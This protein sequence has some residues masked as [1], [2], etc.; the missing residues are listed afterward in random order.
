MIKR[1]ILSLILLITLS[2]L[3]AQTFI[4]GT[5]D[6]TDSPN[7][8][9]DEFNMTVS[10]VGNLFA[11]GNPE[12][13]SKLLNLKLK[14]THPKTPDLTITL[15]SPEGT[16][17]I[18]ADQI[19]DNAPIEAV[20]DFDGTVL[21]QIQTD[22]DIS[23]GEN[24]FTGNFLPQGLGANDLFGSPERFEAFDN[25]N[26]DGVWTLTITDGTST[27]EGTL[28]DWSM[29]F[30][31]NFK[32]TLTDDAISIFENDSTELNVIANDS[33]PENGLDTNTF[34]LI[35]TTDSGS[36]SI[37]E[38]GIVKY[39]PITGF[40]GSDTFTYS[41]CDTNQTSLCDT[42]MVVF[43]VIPNE[44]PV[45]L[46]DLDTTVQNTPVTI[47][48]IE[49]DTDFNGKLDSN[50]VT[51]IQTPQNGGALLTEGNQ[52][53]YSPDTGFSGNDTFTYSICDFGT[54]VLCDTA[55]V[56][57]T[58]NPD[59]P[60]VATNDFDTTAEITLVEISV[61]INDIDPEGKLDTSSLAVVMEA[62]NGIAEVLSDGL[63]SYLPDTG[64]LGTDSFSYSVCD[65]ATPKNCDT[66]WV[67][68]QVNP[69]QNPIALD[70]SAKTVE[71][72]EIE[73][74]VLD[75]DSDF[76]G[77]LDSAGI[78]VVL[79]PN[80]GSITNISDKGVISYLPNLAF[81][82]RDTFT[83]SVCDIAT[84]KNCDTAQVIVIVKENTAPIA[85]DD[86]AKTVKSTEIEIE[87]LN[88]D[89]DFDGTLDSAN[90]LVITNP[91]N[92][93]ITVIGSKGNIT[94][95][96][97]VGFNGM[98]T[99]TYSVCDLASN[100]KCDT[101]MVVITISEN[102]A[103]IALNDSI[104][105]EDGELII[106][107]VLN[108]DT[109]ETPGL[110][111]ASVTLITNPKNGMA[112]A[113]D[114]GNI[115][116]TSEFGFAGN[117]TLTY[118][119]CDLGNSALCDTA[120]LVI[121]I[122]AYSNV[123][124]TLENDSA[125]GSSSAQNPTLT[126]FVIG[127]DSDERNRLDTISLAIVAPTNN[128]VATVS[129][130]G[131][132]SYTPSIGFNGKDTLSY[133]VCDRE[134]NSLCDTAM[135]I[136]IIKDNTAPIALNDSAITKEDVAIS[137]LVL[138][139]DTDFENDLD[140]L[141]LI[142][143]EDP[144]NGVVAI[145]NASTGEVTYTPNSG[146]FGMDTF[147]YSV[148]DNGSP[149][150]CDTAVVVIT[151][152][153]EFENIAPVALNDSFEVQESI[154]FC[155]NV[156]ANDSDQFGG[157]DTASLE[158]IT[159]A[160][161]GVLNFGEAGE[162]CYTASDLF[163]G[164]D[165]F[166]YA[167]C[168]L[169]DSTLCDT[170]TVYLNVVIRDNLAPIALNDSTKTVE[171]DL[172]EVEVLLNDSDPENDV[173]SI[174][175]ALSATNG[176]TNLVGTD[177]VSYQANNGFLGL[178]SFQYVICDER[179]GCDTAFVFVQVDLFVKPNEA[180][181]A[182]DDS[183]ITFMNTTKEVNVT[184]NDSDPEGKLDLNSLR[185]T[186]DPAVGSVTTLSNGTVIYTPKED[187]KGS[188]IFKYEICDL[189]E[190]VLCAEATVRVSI[191]EKPT[192]VNSNELEV[193]VYPNPTNGALFIDFN[194]AVSKSINVQ[195]F[196]SNGALL[197]NIDV[198]SEID[199]SDLPSGIYLV[200]LISADKVKTLRVQKM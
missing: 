2:N 110:D 159:A 177:K 11:T 14:I 129:G 193:T 179:N 76:D 12:A 170:A 134:V 115:E 84:P 44:T 81:I 196:N 52:I 58:V 122:A 99:F 34:T 40:S 29:E 131:K 106:A 114:M 31:P 128:G 37:I 73:I 117:D 86:S 144:T 55:M 108:N 182:L 191:I 154:E 118:S 162:I 35:S 4:G 82:G 120:Q 136:F 164:T 64:F 43:T 30:I 174:T 94:Y 26:A 132:I 96:P 150:K 60:P 24:P 190:P 39:V 95:L 165:S 143:T 145:T 111:S 47:N 25:E 141:S 153:E 62:V 125:S 119:V 79:N 88:N 56:I 148:C 32:P 38:N 42:A 171:E 158:I 157:L 185:I 175:E 186:Q 72:D 199:L 50:S 152:E 112:I 68:I 103:P 75:N 198:N 65:S 17:V 97:N 53:T 168:D 178:D 194:S 142:I 36:L 167:I 22:P 27:N 139:N 18:I 187:F 192:S 100:P 69:D 51:V 74:S 127:N 116:Y 188:V 59:E 163:V 123:A 172:I 135:V 93:T 169:H 102:K 1:L 41:I 16:T 28:V 138:E 80:N 133:K 173:L 146:I 98:D 121:K 140:T 20:G 90:V 151:I 77:S 83:Y 78:T 104:D 109:S 10:G 149:I 70:D 161:N 89:T 49:N 23:D 7:P 5:G 85:L 176:V 66:A 197:K 147:F 200:K 45:A 180:P 57:I 8:D 113:T 61:L 124:P 107:F 19:G 63:I 130:N 9:G 87:V 189:G 105:A 3:N 183:L 67:F 126:V 13:T 137:I 155:L 184:T 166:E 48:V 156:V 92:G 195:I 21:T 160:S 91:V 6:I 181:I 46:N 71:A 54:P 33:D 101:A 15:T